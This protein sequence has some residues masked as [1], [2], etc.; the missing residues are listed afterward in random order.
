MLSSCLLQGA[1]DLVQIHL[2]ELGPDIFAR[3]LAQ[4]LCGFFGVGEAVLRKFTF[5]L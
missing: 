4:D 3:Q 1:Q 2:L 5:S